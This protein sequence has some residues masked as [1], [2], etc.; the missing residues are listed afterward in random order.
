MSG[1]GLER[2]NERHRRQ[3]VA[4]KV[5]QERAVILQLRFLRRVGHDAQIARQRIANSAVEMEQQRHAIT[6]AQLQQILAGENQRLRIQD[7]IDSGCFASSPDRANHD[8]TP[9]VEWLLQKLR[10]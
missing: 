5:V 8:G 6:V 1:Q 3:R 9:L 2:T 7:H 4:L 10:S